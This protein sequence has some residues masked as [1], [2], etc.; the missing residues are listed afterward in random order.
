MV[1]AIVMHRNI[2]S[3]NSLSVAFSALI[4]RLPLVNWS[5]LF[6]VDGTYPEEAPQEQNVVVKKAG[7]LL[8]AKS[9][10]IIFLNQVL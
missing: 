8:L 9:G 6:T 3:I 4:L 1:H 5:E 7:S 2:F 10:V